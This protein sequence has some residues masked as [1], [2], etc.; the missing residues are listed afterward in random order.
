MEPAPP[1]LESEVLTT[2]PRW[3]AAW[4]LL[5]RDDQDELQSQACH[6]MAGALSLPAP[7]SE[8]T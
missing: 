2:G 7:A 4:A 1:A 6:I 8:E 3:G 5:G